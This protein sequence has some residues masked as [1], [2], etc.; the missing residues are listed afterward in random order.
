MDK[1]APITA[2]SFDPTCSTAENGSLNL[3]ILLPTS[4][5]P[6]GR[7]GRIRWPIPQLF[8]RRVRFLPIPTAIQ[9]GCE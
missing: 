4:F 2:L 8:L 3:L 9:L 5:A 6:R 7:Q 1:L